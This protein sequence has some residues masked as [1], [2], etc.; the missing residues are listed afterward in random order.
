MGF[1]DPKLSTQHCKAICS[2]EFEYIQ[3][4]IDYGATQT[5]FSASPISETICV[6]KL[7]MY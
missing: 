1:R 4:W 6:S 5:I 3:Q 7:D 2:K